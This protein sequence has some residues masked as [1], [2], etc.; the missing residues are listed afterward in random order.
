MHNNKQWVV[1]AF[2]FCFLG[3]FWFVEQMCNMRQLLLKLDSF[4]TCNTLKELYVR[5]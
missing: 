2:V 4:L 5:D 1:V 3:S